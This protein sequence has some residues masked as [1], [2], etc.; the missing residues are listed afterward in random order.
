M[1]DSM[2][3]ELEKIAGLEK[4]AIGLMLGGLLA[5]GATKFGPKLLKGMGRLGKKTGLVGSGGQQKLRQARGAIATHRKGLRRGGRGALGVDAAI[6]VGSMASG[7]MKSV[8]QP[9][10]PVRVRSPA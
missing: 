8:G 9:R 3:D 7:G 6:G 4:N 5:R 10:S 2:R 1:Y